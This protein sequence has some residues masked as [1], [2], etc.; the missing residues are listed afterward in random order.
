MQCIVYYAKRYIHPY[1][2]SGNGAYSFNWVIGGVHPGHAKLKFHFK[3]A[4][5]ITLSALAIEFFMHLKYIIKNFKSTL[6]VLMDH[7]SY[8]EAVTHSESPMK[9]EATFEFFF[10]NNTHKRTLEF[11][12]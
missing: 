4:T 10:F 8:N 11:K 7:I 12:I 6:N 3:I 1:F 9:S 5:V 2:L